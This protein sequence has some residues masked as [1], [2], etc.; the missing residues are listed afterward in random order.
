MKWRRISLPTLRMA[1]PRIST[2]AKAMKRE[3]CV[4]SRTNSCGIY[5]TTTAMNAP[6]RWKVSCAGGIARRLG[7]SSKN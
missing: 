7:N 5:A 4:S 2:A 1:S 6:N 3:C